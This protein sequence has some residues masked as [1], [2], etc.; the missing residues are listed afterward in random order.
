MT[1]VVYRPTGL[2]SDKPM[3]ARMAGVKIS[4]CLAPPLAF[5]SAPR[6]SSKP[7]DWSFLHIGPGR[8]WTFLTCSPGPSSGR[9]LNCVLTLR[10]QNC[11]KLVWTNWAL[12]LTQVWPSCVIKIFLQV[13]PASFWK[14][15][16]QQLAFA[17]SL[18]YLFSLFMASCVSTFWLFMHFCLR[19]IV[20]QMH[21]AQNLKSPMWK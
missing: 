16:F 11:T 2:V 3:T 7:Q 18:L 21:F 9:G 17:K 12:L 10:R 14:T 6:Q 5:I 1:E 13:V 15:C 20:E 8:F 4:A 19:Y